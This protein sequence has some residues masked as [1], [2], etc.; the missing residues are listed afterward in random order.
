MN[1]YFFR[2]MSKIASGVAMNLGITGLG[3][4]GANAD[5][6]ER[7]KKNKLMPMPYKPAPIENPLSSTS[8]YG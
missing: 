3:L 4:Y 8:M 1:K 6:K 5:A 7:V 2:E